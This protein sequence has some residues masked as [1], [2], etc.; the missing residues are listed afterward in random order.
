MKNSQIIEKLK[1]RWGVKNGYQVGMI[2]LVFAATG[3]SVMFLKKPLYAL[4]GFTE[5]TPLWIRFVFYCLTILPAYQVILLI[6]G[7]LF[8]Q[9][10]FFWNFEKRMFSRIKSL[11]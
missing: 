5:A 8:G 7:Y 1:T 3:F 11:F 2:L 4:V 6:W 10:E 9:F